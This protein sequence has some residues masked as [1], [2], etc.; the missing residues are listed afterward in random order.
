MSAATML[1][2]LLAVQAL[3]VLLAAGLLR[4]QG[5]SGSAALGAGV[6]SLVLVRALV[7]T[8][9]FVMSA[10]SASPT[11]PE[12]RPGV[13][14]WL[15]LW[16]EEFAASMLQSSWYTPWGRARQVLF[17][18]GAAI[19]VL[20]I[21][22]YGCNSGYWHQLGRRLEAV[23]ISYASIDLAP[24]TGDIDGYAAQVDAAVAA[25]RAA[26]GA[27][28]II[29]V[30]HSMG[31]LVARAWLRAAGEHAPLARLVTLGTPHH[32]TVLANLGVGINAAQMRR[33]RSG[34]A[35][36]WLRQLAASEH[37]ATRARMVSIWTHHDNIVSP[38]TSSCL[39][40]ARN[41]ALAGMGHVALGSNRRVLDHVMAEIGACNGQ[42]GACAVKLN[43]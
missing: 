12:C 20:L 15:R 31:G 24:V 33:A 4:G 26:S 25:L 5:W 28:A 9:N 14:G 2:L 29:I 23:R 1:R 34:Q 6:G 7:F 22:G 37:A 39:E 35:S 30:A 38:Q 36:A 21:H 43:V 40:G 41:I 13:A 10:G 8:N 32:G 17:D 19:P 3:A 18:D 27:P 16:G 11:P 42:Q